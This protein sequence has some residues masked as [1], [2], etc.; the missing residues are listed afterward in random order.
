[1]TPTLARIFVYP[2]KSAAG[3]EIDAAELDAFG[4]RHD[5][6]FMLI[7]A[8]G[9]FMTQRAHSRMALIRI[10]LEADHLVLSAE[11]RQPLHVPL[12]PDGP[13]CVVRVWNDDVS[14]VR[15]DSAD[16]RWL[17]DVLGTPCTLVHMP[18]STLRQIDRVY[19]RPG[20]RV[21]FTDGFPLLLLTTGSMNELN[22]RLDRALSVR[23]FRP[24]LLIEHDTPHVEDTWLRVRVATVDL[25]IVKPCA[26][27]AITT[28]DPDT[29]GTGREPLRTLAE[30]RARGGKV[31]FGQNAIHAGEGTLR[32]G[33]EVS[34]LERSYSATSDP[35]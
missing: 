6:R 15:V 5:R 31:Y 12:V 16:T 33:D 18:D 13:A 22:R 28:V 30:Y 4:I 1:M 20:E 8:D 25:R 34:V 26:R 3:I 23:R 27:C 29:G 24:N 32:T 21:A 2:V 35:L 11:G 9:G 19:G 10:A 14:A 17:E 7:D